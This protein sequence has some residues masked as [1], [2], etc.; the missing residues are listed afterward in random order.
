[1]KK[2]AFDTAQI[3][4]P[5]TPSIRM[6]YDQE[7]DIL[8]LFFGEN[9]SATGIQLTDHILLRINQK[10]RRAVSLMFLHFSIL[11][12]RTEFGPRS[13]SLDKVEELPEELREL[14]FYLITSL[15]INQFLKVSNFQISPVK[16]IP[17]TYVEPTY[18]LATA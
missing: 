1:M 2:L 8:E 12:E 4:A 6:V 16:H 13:Y 7:G 9:E 15:P 18:F 3:N 14:V 11:T 17:L 5:G 10:S